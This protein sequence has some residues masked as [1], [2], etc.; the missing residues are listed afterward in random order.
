MWSYTFTNYDT[1]TDGSNAITPRPNWP[2]RPEVDVPISTTPPMNETDYSA[3]DFSL[4]KDI[5]RQILIKSNINNW[6]KCNPGTG[7]L[8]AWKSGTVKC[9][10]VK[11]VTETCK[12]RPAPSSFAASDTYGPT[13]KTTKNM[14]YY[15]G[16]T[17][18]NW[19]THDPCGRNQGNQ[20]QNMVN[21]HGNIYIRNTR[22]DLGT[23]GS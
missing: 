4:W 14:Y 16:Y 12:D 23:E 18:K 9:Q 21:S 13:F 6:L 10:I 2:V 3:M 20:V 8:V 1:F 5:G 22:T 11:Q 19:P 7:S 17:K 15:D